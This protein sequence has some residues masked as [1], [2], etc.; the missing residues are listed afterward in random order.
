[1]KVFAFLPLAFIAG[2]H[3]FTLFAP[4]LALCA[5]AVLLRHHWRLA[6]A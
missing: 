3:G 6:S 4:Y 2:E 5:G 1:M